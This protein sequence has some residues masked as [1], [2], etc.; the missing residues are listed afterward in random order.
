MSFEEKAFSEQ[1]GLP[2]VEAKKKAARAKKGVP[3]QQ[4]KTF[5]TINGQ[6]ILMLTVKRNGCYSSYFGRVDKL[7]HDVL[8]LKKKEWKS[9]G[10]W[11]EAH[12]VQQQVSEY[13][14]I[15]ADEYEKAK[16]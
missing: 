2:A 1:Q 3:Q 9:K 14:Q 5:Y 15:L 12:Q 8:D 16:K 6:K 13:Q 11:L 4:G 7:G 10:Q